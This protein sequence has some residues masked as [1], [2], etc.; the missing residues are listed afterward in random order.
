MY[1]MKA[2]SQ[3]TGLSPD[4]LRAWERRHAVVHPQREEN[5]RRS[6]SA[7]DLMRLGLLKQAVDQGQPIRKLAGL[8]ND[9]L[10]AL[11]AERA[12]SGERDMADAL[13]Q[14]ILEGVEAYD[15]EATRRAVSLVLATLPLRVAVSD[16]L[17]PA[18]RETGARWEAGVFTVAQERMLSAI[19]RSVLAGLLH[20][21]D[22]PG[23]RPIIALATLPGERHETGILLA[24]LAAVSVGAH[25]H[26]IGSDLP[27]RETSRLAAAAEADLII[28]A[29][30]LDPTPA[31]AL[32]ELRELRRLVPESTGIWVGGAGAAAAAAVL[33]EGVT[34]IQSY[35]ELTERLRVLQS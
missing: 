10:A 24:A 16:V 33:P 29:L 21:L 23:A 1:S 3:I 34:L 17:A 18:L 32:G 31:E 5:G 11:V 20:S 26:F 28:V 2:V 9:A 4:T 15:D 35:S 22:R 27:A 30:V 8:G 25:C 6:Y 19:L 13:L 12:P 7:D 14:R